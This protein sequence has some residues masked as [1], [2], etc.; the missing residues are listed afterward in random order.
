MNRSQMQK[1]AIA[2]GAV[3]LLTGALIYGAWRLTRLDWLMFAGMLTII[4]GI[5]AFFAGLMALVSHMIHE[6]KVERYSGSRLW[7]HGVLI[8]CLL[9]MNFPAAAYFTIS[10]IEVMERYTFSVR[11]ES[12]HTIESLVVTGPGIELELGPIVPG[13]RVQQHFQ[14]VHDGSLV[15]AARQ[16][17][18]Q[19]GGE[20]EGYVTN[21][22]GGN[23]SIRVIKR[24]QFEIQ[25]DDV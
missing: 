23:K 10:A 9:F 18:L 12:N 24:G 5:P 4:A 11:N 22:V 15:F 1:L 20:L 3:P 17:E 25:A 21:G 7:L 16:Q 13:Q 19:F 8:G 6:R 2:L 14:I